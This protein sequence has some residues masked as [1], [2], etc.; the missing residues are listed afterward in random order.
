MTRE[1][2]M[3]RRLIAVST[4]TTLALSLMPSVTGALELKGK[5]KKQGMLLP[6]VQKV[7][8]SGNSSTQTK[9]SGECGIPTR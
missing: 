3:L 8:E 6:A 7:R 1:T 4:A 5:Q 9:G 2:P